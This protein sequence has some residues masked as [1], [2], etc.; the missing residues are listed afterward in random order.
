M[1]HYD[2]CDTAYMSA[3]KETL[4]KL[5][6]VQNIG[7]RTILLARK[8]THIQDMHQALGLLPLTE[9]RDLH[10]SLLCHKNIYN[11]QPQSLSKYFKPATLVGGR[12]TW[13]TESNSMYV[14]NVLTDKGRQA[15]EYR[16]PLHWN[17]LDDNVKTITKFASFQKELMKRSSLE[18]D[19]HPT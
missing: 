12:R 17:N 9:R 7:C 1:P 6:V 16:G 5:Q 8:R 18:L 14:P 3:N 13:G 15:I 4:N 11:E 10:L 2:Y 19:N